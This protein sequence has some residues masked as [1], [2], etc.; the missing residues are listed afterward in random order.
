MKWVVPHSG[1]CKLYAA[2]PKGILTQ[3]YI[4]SLTDDQL[5]ET[6]LAKPRWATIRALAA[7][8]EGKSIKDTLYTYAGVSGVGP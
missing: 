2:A 6:G 3:A 5:K 4:L 7:C 8:S 1:R